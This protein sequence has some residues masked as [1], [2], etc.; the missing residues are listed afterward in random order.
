MDY[1]EVVCP[2]CGSIYWR[3]VEKEYLASPYIWK[4]SEYPVII[5]EDCRVGINERK[6]RLDGT[7]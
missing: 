5:C 7:R 3:F 2:S 1:V 6:V 4:R